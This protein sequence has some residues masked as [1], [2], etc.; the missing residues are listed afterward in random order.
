MAITFFTGKY[1]FLSNFFQHTHHKLIYADN[2]FTHVEGA[3]Q[4]AK[5]KSPDDRDL[6]VDQS[7]QYTKKLGRIVEIRDDWEEAKL[8]VMENLLRQKFQ[9]KGLRQQLLDTGDEEII[10]G[11]YWH[12]TY[13]GVCNG[14]GENHLGKLLMKLREEYRQ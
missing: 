13:W 4:S 11:N 10:E 9:D 1:A 2:D 3:Y 5:C 7:P 6:F 14:V 8:G 12:D